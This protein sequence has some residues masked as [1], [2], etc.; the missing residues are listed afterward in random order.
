[1]TIRTALDSDDWGDIN[2]A[3]DFLLAYSDQVPDSLTFERAHP[4]HQVVYIDRGHGDP[5]FKAS[6]GDFESG[7]LQIDQVASWYDAKAKAKVA[8]LTHYSDRSNLASITAHLG[9][10]NMYRW[11][12]T[13]DGTVNISGFVPMVGPDLVQTTPASML[14]IHADL[15]LVMNPGWHPTPKPSQLAS[16]Q[17]TLSD[18]QRDLTAT[19]GRLSVVASTLNAIH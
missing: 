19:A 15:S 13:L 14:G 18:A 5:G 3:V 11:V 8:F 17:A 10:R 9:G 4:N 12:A 16:A 1:M 7:A 6:I 2:V